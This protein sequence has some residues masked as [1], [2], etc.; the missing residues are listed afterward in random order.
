M[1]TFE[2]II[3]RVQTAEKPIYRPEI[4]DNISNNTE[5]AVVEM[6]VKCWDESPDQRP[7]FD[8]SLKNLQRMSRG[9]YLSYATT[10]DDQ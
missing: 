2:D 9:R 5:S 4:P 10:I 7:P 6:M 8:D 3:K 1:C